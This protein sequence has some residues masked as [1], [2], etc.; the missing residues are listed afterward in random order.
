MTQPLENGVDAL[1][2]RIRDHLKYSICTPLEK[3][4]QDDIGRAVALACRDWVADRLLATEQRLASADPKRLYYLS[5]EFLMGRALGNNLSNLD[6]Y[7][8]VDA[9]VAALGYRLS[10]LL[11]GEYDP[12]LG[13]GGLGRLAA[14]FLDSLASL[15]LPGFGYGIRYDFGLF[16]QEFRNGWQAEL[17]DHWEA[18]ASPW[19]IERSQHTCLV[20]LYGRVVEDVD[21]EGHYNP[22]WLDWEIIVGVP[23]D[24]PVVGY[25][26]N[27]VNTLRLFAARAPDQ[28]NMEIFNDGDYFR[29]VEQQIASETVS[30]VLYPS[31]SLEEGKE[32]RLIQEYFLVACSVRDIVRD[33]LSRHQDMHQFSDFTAIQLNDTHPALTVA[34]LMRLLVDEHAIPWDTAF[35]IT[36]RTC[37]YT[38]HTLLPE[39]LEKWSVGL[40]R[41]VLPRHLQIIY[42]INRRHL[43][44]VAKRFPDSPHKLQSLSLIEEGDHQQVRMAHLAIVGGHAINGVAA[45]HSELVKTDLVPDFHAL[46]PDRFQNKTNGVTPRRWIKQANP[47]LSRVLSEAIGD[48]WVRDLSEV[49]RIEPLAGDAAFQQAIHDAKRRNK[50]LLAEVIRTTAGVRVDPDSLFDVQAKRMHE[51]KR[52]LLNLMHIVHEYL[53]ATEDNALPETPRTYIFGGK[54]APGYFLAK[55]IIK[56][57]NNVATTINS[58]ARLHGVMKV[59]YLPDYR[60]SL[61]ERI[62]PGADLSEQISTAGKEASGT[63]NMKFAMNGALTIGTLDGANIEMAEEIGEENMYIF[64]LTVSEVQSLQRKHYNPWDAYHRSDRA[65]RVMDAI[66]DDRFCHSDPGLFRPIYDAILNGGD[67]YL[68]LADFDAY[69]DTH[70]QVGRDYL[71]TANWTRKAILNIARMDKFSSDRTIREYARDI[72]GLKPF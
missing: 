55:R 10:D 57:I 26:G 43:E 35:E 19:L 2:I 13:N 47:A 6:L 63:G 71:D 52:Q 20:P 44:E 34:E 7:E 29:A 60:V 72:W 45:V 48:N 50:A 39:A 15:D 12:A 69:L 3:A 70:A 61:A 54:A 38:N 51:Y 33:Y 65:R 58:D 37:A 11:E 17:P 27:T 5:M 64:G 59:V 36:R 46:W 53:R 25:S 14:C 40:L 8:T 49:R 16:R 56:L 1:Q 24:L 21:R 41:K 30:K 68:H 31:D 66:G 9:A 18:A 67:P 32:L 62:M 22:M 42:E 28:F 4:T 23:Y